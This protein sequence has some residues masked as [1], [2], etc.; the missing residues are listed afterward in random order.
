MSAGTQERNLFG[1]TNPVAGY[2]REIAG[3]AKL[4][5]KAEKLLAARIRA[6]DRTAKNALVQ[7]NLKFVVAVCRNYE[8]QGLP[9]GDLIN[10]GNLGLMRAAD[11]FDENQ[12]C[13]FISYAV[14]WIRQ[15]IMNALAEQTRDVT[16]ST[17]TTSAIHRIGK[18]IR[19]LS[20]S[21]GREP[22][23]EELE[24]E[25]GM[26]ALRIRDCLNLMGPSLSMDYP[27]GIGDGTFA[28]SVPEG[29]ESG[30]EDILDRF[31][32]RRALETV[33]KNLDR[34]ERQVIESLYG[35]GSENVV[36]LQSLADRLGVSK[37]RVR[38]LK[39]KALAKLRGFLNLS[40]HY[41]CGST[42]FQP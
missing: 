31:R 16:L 26:K 11:R 22:S 19:A 23:V 7:A 6:G 14:W 24:L 12:E 10:E 13:R 28:D 37:E 35:I 17:A 39:V 9:L 8:N 41:P 27:T 30:T 21:L 32:T 1:E 4:T 42:G 40:S 29:R 25:T 33:I 3:T 34:R 5:T 38:Q 18:A 36:S 2:L 20:Q 15:G